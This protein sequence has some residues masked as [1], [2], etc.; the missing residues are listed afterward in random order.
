ERPVPPSDVPGE[1]ASPTQPI[2]SRAA[3]FE[4]QGATVDD[5]V[6]FTPEIRAIAVKAIAG[7]RSGPLFTPP[8][9]EGTIQHPGSAG[10]ANWNGAAVDPD[11]GFLYVPSR[12][13]YSVNK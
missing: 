1:K 13:L 10:G 12:N 2:P 4:Q 7:F 6:D 11:T 8:S 9:V 3:P 5:L